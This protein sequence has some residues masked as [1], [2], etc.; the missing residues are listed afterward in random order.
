MEKRIVVVTT[1]STRRGVFCGKLLSEKGDVVELANAKMAVYWCSD[2]KGVLSLA[3]TGPC[4]GCRITPKIPK[5]KL[6]GVTSIMDC[7]DKAIKNWEKDT[8]D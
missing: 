2:V 5:I 7:S 4:K 3:A 8:W 1:D 6:N